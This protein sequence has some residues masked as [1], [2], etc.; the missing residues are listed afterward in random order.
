MSRLIAMGLPRQICYVLA[1]MIVSLIPL[2]IKSPYYLDLIITLLHAVLGM[3]FLI[4][5]RTG[6]INMGLA[7]LWGVGA[8]TS[9][10]LVTKLHLSFWIA[11]PTAALMTA[12]L[13]LVVGCFLIGSGSTGFNFVILS[14]VIGMLFVVTVGSVP[15]LGG[16]NGISNIPP[17]SAIPIPFSQPIEFASKVEFY[18]FALGL[19]LIAVLVQKAFYSCS[20]GKAWSAIGLNPRLAQS[21][22]IDLFR[23]RLLA[24]VLASGLVGLVGSF[25]AHYTSFVIPNTYGIFTNIYIQIYAILGGIGYPILGPLVGTAVMVF[26]PEL[27]RMTREWTSIFSGFLLILLVLFLPKGILSLIDQYVLRVGSGV[28]EIL[29][30]ILPVRQEGNGAWIFRKITSYLKSR[31]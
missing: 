1:I 27:L 2:F 5:L 26:L 11:M 9:A 28:A 31:V 17:P 30:S 3:A 15:L 21:V 8:Y 23:Y 29:L 22:G 7:A 25:D 24:F 19:F 12:L 13:A 16:Y 20:I 10:I 18:Y 4:T 6:L 14:S